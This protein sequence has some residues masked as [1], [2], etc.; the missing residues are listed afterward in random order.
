MSRR[1]TAAPPPPPCLVQ[2]TC[3]YNGEKLQPTVRK[4]PPRP[5]KPSPPTTKKPINSPTLPKKPPVPAKKSGMNKEVPVNENRQMICNSANISGQENKTTESQKSDPVTNKD[6]KV[7]EISNLSE[8]VSSVKS[9]GSKPNHSCS[10]SKEGATE[11]LSSLD[12]KEVTVTEKKKKGKERKRSI[13]LLSSFKAKFGTAKDKDE[14]K[15]SAKEA[16]EHSSKTHDNEGMRKASTSSDKSS[17]SQTKFYVDNDSNCSD[18]ANVDKGDVFSAVTDGGECSSVAK[19]DKPTLSDSPVLPVKNRSNKSYET[20]LKEL[21]MDNVEYKEKP[22]K[23]TR[24]KRPQLMDSVRLDFSSSESLT[25]SSIDSSV[26]ETTQPK[27]EADLKDIIRYDSKR[28]RRKADAF[29]SFTTEDMDIF[30]RK[31]IFFF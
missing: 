3:G 16:Q 14:L 12:V 9:I 21:G 4:K 27:V 23:P 15:C 18:E 28:N 6:Y 17:N 2:N 19:L 13:G 24:K 20:A 10:A 5:Y 1:P 26:S 8:P 25:R 7:Q 22:Q 30:N 31:Q 11:E 29:K